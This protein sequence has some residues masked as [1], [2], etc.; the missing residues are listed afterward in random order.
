MEF[1]K[2]LFTEP[3]SFEA[4]S[5]AVKEKGIKLADLSKGEYVS[6]EKL[7]RANTAL[8]E[9]KEN[10]SSLT[11]ELQALKESNATA[12]EWKTKY[13]EL[14]EKQRL[15]EEKRQ[16][17]EQ[18]AAEK[19][20][21]EAYI[22]DKKLEWTNPLIAEGYFRRYQEAKKSD[23]YKGKTS[24]DIVHALTKDDKTAFKTAQPEV[25]LPGGKP[26]SG[27]VTKEDFGKMGYAERF[28]IKTEHPE[29]YQEL[30][31]KGD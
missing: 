18:E 7:D 5:K 24:A 6:K 26:F 21:F 12:E 30:T 4:F 31:S 14:A 2:E 20:E 9:E 17:E 16:K 27:S 23:E 15:A 29:L 11:S 28:K 10:A 22:S 19:A 1:L 13:D 3:L 8:A 25:Q